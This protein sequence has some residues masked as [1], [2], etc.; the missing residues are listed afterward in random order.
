MREKEQ[1]VKY[2]HITLQLQVFTKITIWMMNRGWPKL[3]VY[4][5]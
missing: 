5:R 2:R 3:Q 1:F 4:A